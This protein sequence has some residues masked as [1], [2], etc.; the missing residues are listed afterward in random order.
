[1]EELYSLYR[2]FD[3][4]N[5]LLYVGLSLRAVERIRTHKKS[6][7]FF[8]SVAKITI[9]HLSSRSELCKAEATAIKNE[10][11]LYNK[12]LNQRRCPQCNRLP[13]SHSRRCELAQN[14]HLTFRAI[15]P[16]L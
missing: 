4:R 12:Q 2:M 1:M 5:R 6:R 3:G 9:E 15:C 10:R 8:D 7:R 14:H 11:P 16:I 13:G